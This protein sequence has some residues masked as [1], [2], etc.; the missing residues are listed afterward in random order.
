M[1][2]SDLTLAEGEVVVISSDSYAGVVGV[3]IA[4]NFGIV[5]LTASGATDYIVGDSVGFKSDD[6]I[7]FMIISGQTFYKVNTDNIEFKEVIPP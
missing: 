4:L 3:D 2:L 7:A 5:Q 6:A 1:A